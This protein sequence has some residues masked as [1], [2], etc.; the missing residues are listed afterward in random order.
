[1]SGDT[2]PR[3]F[4]SVQKAGLF[5][6][7]LLFMLLIHLPAFPPLS[8]K[9]QVVLA[10][11]LWMLI[12]WISEA[13]QLSVTAL[14]P[15]ILFP[16]TG[17][18]DLDQTTGAYGN[19][20]IFLFMGGFMIALALEKWQLHLRIALSIVRLTGTNADGIIF[21]FML[22]TGALSMWISNTATTVM[23]LPIASSVITLLVKENL[24][25][26]P[27]QLANFS[28][29]MMLGIAYAANIGGIATLV[30]TPP[31]TVL[32]SIIEDRYGYDI[33]FADWAAVGFPFSLMMLLLMYWVLVKIVYPNR[34]GHFKGS[35]ELI[36]KELD[37]LGKL[38]KGERLTLMIFTGTALLWILHSYL[39]IIFPWLILD[40]T[41]IAIVGTIALFICPVDF[42][43]GEFVL[44]WED[45]QRLPWGILLL[46]GG[47]LALA[48]ALDEVGLVRLIGEV[49]AQNNNL[50]FFTINVILIALS[51]FLTEIMSNVALVTIIIPL[52]AGISVSLGENPLWA[53]IPV[54]MAAS[55]AFMLPMSTPPNAIVFAS[56][57]ITVAQMAKA[58]FVLN[59][60][61]IG[62]LVILAQFWIPY[63]FEIV[64][65]VVPE[66]GVK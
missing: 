24:E 31:N 37:K 33:S 25:Y 12:W 29:C 9:A 3:Y 5:L 55:C 42:K 64:P 63:I 38:S 66:W 7:P 14:L 22:A 20:I 30:G 53:C 23:M 17:V 46:F 19:K 44:R 39:E 26:T 48:N 16:M 6:G 2:S 4:S 54:T 49:V 59:L 8:E 32:V 27:R 56:G 43:K 61:S 60:I 1:M 58:G 52:V 62:L 34:M 21:G 11:M 51:L 13:T 10:V 57:H 65:G 36:Q 28:L 15:I 50:G 40:D 47:G 41:I 35:E 18:L 45:T